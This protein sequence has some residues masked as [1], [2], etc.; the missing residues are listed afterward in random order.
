MGLILM[1]PEV[2][3]EADGGGQFWVGLF[4]LQAFFLGLAF[5]FWLPSGRWAV[6]PE[7]GLSFD[8]CWVLCWLRGS[9]SS[10]GVFSPRVELGL[11]SWQAIV[12]SGPRFLVQR[13]LSPALWG[14]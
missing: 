7:L 9:F 11:S 3:F 4:C 1:G 2:W 5:K 6:G 14:L 8:S 13:L 10:C 12:A